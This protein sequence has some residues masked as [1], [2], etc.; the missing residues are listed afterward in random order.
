MACAGCAIL[1]GCN[2]E[3]RKG[4]D[5]SW[6]TGAITLSIA[7]DAPSLA[8][9]GGFARK[10]FAN[11]NG[12]DPVLIVRTSTTQVKVMTTVCTHQQTIID[13]PSNDRA[14]CPNHGAI[15]SVQAANFG[16]NIGGQVSTTLPQFVA[17]LAGDVLTI[18]F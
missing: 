3:R 4:D 15:Y 17:T 18:T 13:D 10:T 6:M 5:S 11:R 14:V 9:V 1:A 7:A 2:S 8:V 16:E 12:G